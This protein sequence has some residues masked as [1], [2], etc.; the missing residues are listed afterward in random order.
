MRIAITADLHANRTYIDCFLR[1]DLMETLDEIW[2]LGDIVGRGPHPV[3]TLQFL[4]TYVKPEMWVAGNHDAFVWDLIDEQTKAAFNED[5][6]ETLR[7]HRAIINA[8][9][10]VCAW[11]AEAFVDEDRIS[12]RWDDRHENALYGIVHA[13]LNDPLGTGVKSPNL[14]AWDQSINYKLGENYFEPMQLEQERRGWQPKWMVLFCGHS[15]HPVY[16]TAHPDDLQGTFRNHHFELQYGIEM[17]IPEGLAV[18]NPGSLGVPRF[19]SPTFVVLDT[20]QNTIVFHALE[21]P[22]THFDRLIID[23]RAGQY[24]PEIIK[25]FQVPDWSSSDRS[26]HADVYESLKKREQ[27][28]IRLRCR[29]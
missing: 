12:P 11:T 1:L 27:D 20:D 18:I 7:K 19:G 3:E 9:S 23:M 22:D 16:L 29:D 21:I 13:A 5:E 28:A 10:D 26:D 8:N 14:Y 2:C 15:H 25:M 6:Q 4:M 24:P 17:E